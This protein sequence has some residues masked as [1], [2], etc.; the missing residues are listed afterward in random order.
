[1]IRRLLLGFATVA[2]ISSA[3]T[4]AD[5]PQWRGPNRDGKSGDTG[6]L[7]SWPADGPKLLWKLEDV[8]AGYGQPVVIG[9][10]FY[11][12]G[13]SSNKKNGKDSIVCLSAKDG[14]KVWEKE[15]TTANGNYMDGWGG[16]PRNTPTVDGAHIYVLGAT[17]DLACLKLADGSN[18]WSKN[19]VSDFGGKIPTWGYSE[20]VLIDGDSLLCTPGNG[21][22]MVSLDKKT[23]KTIWACKDFTDGAGYSSIMIATVGGMKLYV[24]QTMN[25]S[26]AVRADNG[27][28]MW[29]TGELG[30][31]TAVIPTP[32][33][34]GNL[35]FFTAGY[36][37]GCELVEMKFEGG[38]VDGTLKYSKNKT[39]VN[40][41][42]GVI[43]DGD[44]I[45]GHSDNGGW[46]CLDF[47]NKGE[48]AWQYSKHGKGSIAYADG[49][50]YCYSEGK[51]ELALIE[52]N[53]KEWKQL[54][55]FTIPETSAKR[56]GTS[57]LVWP[58]PVIANG[59]LI[60]RDYEKLFVYNVKGSAE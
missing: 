13:S 31:R 1:M 18:V 50:F 23:G 12:T 19:L 36:G 16:G 48:A 42:G 57:G 6:L 2:A 17:G 40:H 56:K 60:L 39:L 22:G 15:I 11:L 46:T 33:I 51:G 38:K 14:S 7:K 34:D 8:G 52:S 25:S 26:L 44:F 32:I 37:A 27:K 45:Y 59:M 29:K 43:Q 49:L 4:A 58:H 20:S 5:W 21:T 54:G 24:Q 41:H 9:D 28:L 35:A 47:K 10:K 55:K 3:A 53:S 30:R